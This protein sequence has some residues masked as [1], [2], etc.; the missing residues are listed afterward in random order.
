MDY[1]KFIKQKE[2]SISIPKGKIL[3][4]RNGVLSTSDEGHQQFME[5]YKDIFVK[6]PK[7]IGFPIHS[8]KRV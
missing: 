8:E 6:K 1:P 4:F 3:Y 5:M 7:K 2:E